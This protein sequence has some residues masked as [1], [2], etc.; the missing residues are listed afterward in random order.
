MATF[1]SKIVPLYFPTLHN[2][3]SR[4]TRVVAGECFTMDVS[5][6]QTWADSDTIVMYI[7]DTD[8]TFTLRGQI[9][10]KDSG[11]VLKSV[12]PAASSGENYWL[13]QSL[14]GL[15]GR[16][17]AFQLGRIVSGN[18]RSDYESETFRVISATLDI[19]KN[20]STLIRYWGCATDFGW[21]FNTTNNATTPAYIPSIRIFDSIR[22]RVP[23]VNKTISETYAKSYFTCAAEADFVYEVRGEFAPLWWIE[24]MSLVTLQRN[25]EVDS[26]RYVQELEA[27][28]G[29]QYENMPLFKWSMLLR[30]ADQSNVTYRSGCC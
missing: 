7:R 10:D 4:D 9:V 11:E 29:E 19:V 18:F 17:L 3:F 13:S 22:Q 20:C 15:A 14:A 24:K 16:N 25:V 2:D 30:K 8:G 6:Q 12:V 28:L 1:A 23:I 26:V 27:S 21:N 5:W